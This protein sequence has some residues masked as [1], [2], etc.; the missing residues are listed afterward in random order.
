MHRGNGKLAREESWQYLVT[1]T[2]SGVKKEKTHFEGKYELKGKFIS[3]DHPH[4]EYKSVDVDG[5][6]ISDLAEGFANS[7]DT[8]DGVS[9]NLFPLKKEQAHYIFKLEALEDYRGTSVY[10]ATFHPKPG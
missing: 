2:P 1:P 6:V 7:G 9:S 10:R 8:K 4:Y 3:Y 5:D